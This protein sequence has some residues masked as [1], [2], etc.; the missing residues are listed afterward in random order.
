MSPRTSRTS[1]MSRCSAVRAAVLMVVASA[2]IALAGCGGGSSDG[3]TSTATTS[4]PA[5]A[6]FDGLSAEQVL[7]RA[8]SAAGAAE[9]VHVAGSGTSDGQELAVDLRI[10]KQGGT[11]TINI[12]GGRIELIVIGSDVYFKADEA[13]FKTALGDGYTPQ[14]AA[15]LAGRFLKGAATD[16]RLADLAAF[17]SLDKFVADTLKPDG[18]ISR[19]DGKT[20]DGTATV[21]VRDAGTDASNGGILY[22]ADD[23]TD[24]PAAIEQGGSDTGTLRLTEWNAPVKLTPPPSDQ[25][26]DISK[27]G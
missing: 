22:V 15:L 26:V 23:G 19:V 2:A 6:S 7:A 11:G 3:G 12:G 10:S 8:T 16:A 4:T 5:R 14:I 24:L 21:G 1:R 9:S 18:T 25:V 27:L 13:F 17:G 20:F